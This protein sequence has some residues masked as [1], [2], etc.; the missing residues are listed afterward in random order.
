MGSRR[1][2][3]RKSDLRA[4]RRECLGLGAIYFKPHL[5]LLNSCDLNFRRRV[6]AVREPLRWRTTTSHQVAIPPLRSSLG[7]V[8]TASTS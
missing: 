5:P 7:V 8:L 4:A 2:K 3:L 1:G 6:Q